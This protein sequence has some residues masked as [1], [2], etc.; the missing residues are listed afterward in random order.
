[1]YADF[2]FLTE[3]F[4]T[5][6]QTVIQE[7]L[8][9]IVEL[10][11]DETLLFDDIARAYEDILQQANQKLIAFAEKMTAVETFDI[12]GMVTIAYHTTCISAVIGD[13]SM[14]L[15]RK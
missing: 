8:S 11:D 12:R 1:M 10:L 13:V 2:V 14:V 6:Q 5:F 7:A 4:R 9:Q 15:I 3:Q